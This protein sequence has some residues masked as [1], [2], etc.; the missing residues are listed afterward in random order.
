M[1]LGWKI[2]RIIIP[3]QDI[4]WRWIFAHQIIIDDIVP[5]QVIRTH[6]GKHAGEIIAFE[7]AFPARITPSNFETALRHHL[8]QLAIVL[9]WVE[10]TDLEGQ[11]IDTIIARRGQQDSRRL[12]W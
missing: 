3:E 2:G 8:P 11:G 10:D 1:Q 12:Q 4:I 5:D 7:D 6:P 9:L